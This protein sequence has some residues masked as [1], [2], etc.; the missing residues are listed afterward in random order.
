MQTLKNQLSSVR[1]LNDPYLAHYYVGADLDSVDEAIR[2][3][4]ER[5]NLANTAERKFKPSITVQDT[6]KTSE[7]KQPGSAKPVE[8]YFE[9]I[10]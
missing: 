3:I 1:D 4:D 5:I 7:P 10:F 8:S 9:G 6:L 2:R